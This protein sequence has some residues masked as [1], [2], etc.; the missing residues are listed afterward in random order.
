MTLRWTTLIRIASWTGV[1]VSLGIV[2]AWAA[3]LSKARHLGIGG[4]YSLTS[5]S[6]KLTYY[7]ST[8]KDIPLD[9]IAVRRDLLTEA[10][11]IKRSWTWS[12]RPNSALIGFPHWLPISLFLVPSSTVL[13]LDARKRRRSPTACTHCGY[14]R[15]GLAPGSP[16]PECGRFPGAKS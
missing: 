6:G 3:T 12:I 16:C 5:S 7:S 15:S 2:I 8:S 9:L 1:A 10:G 11:K 13:V 4:R 14:D